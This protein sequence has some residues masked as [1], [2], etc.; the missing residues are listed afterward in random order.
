MAGIVNNQTNIAVAPDDQKLKEYY[1]A[2]GTQKHHQRLIDRLTSY[3][4]NRYYLEQIWLANLL[5]I[6]TDNKYIVKEN[7]AIAKLVYSNEER[8]KN[9]LKINNLFPIY[10]ATFA[11]IW[12]SM[13]LISAKPTDPS[14][15]SNYTAELVETI[16]KKEY[17]TWKN[18]GLH[19]V[20]LLYYICC[21]NSFIKSRYNKD[22]GDTIKL[23]MDNSGKLIKEGRVCAESKTPFQMY[24]DYTKH[25]IEQSPDAYETV[26]VHRDTYRAL[27]GIGKD[28]E[29]KV[30]MNSLKNKILLTGS[31]NNNERNINIA[32]YVELAYYYLPPNAVNT[33][34]E[35]TLF[36]SERILQTKNY[37]LSEEIGLPF[38]QA[39]RVET[40]FGYGDTPITYSV[41]IDRELSLFYGQLFEHA[42]KMASP[43]MALPA[44]SR[45]ESKQLA[46]RNVK[47][48]YFNQKYGKPEYVQS[49]EFPRYFETAIAK[50]EE[51]LADTNTIHN[52]S[53][54][55]H[56]PGTRSGLQQA[57]KIE[58]DDSQFIPDV[59]GLFSMYESV[60]YKQIG[61]MKKYYSEKR[62]VQLFGRNNVRYFSFVGK[63]LDNDLT[64]NIEVVAGLPLNRIQ[65]QSMLMQLLTAGIIQK[66]QVAEYLELGETDP[67]FKR[68][69][70]D[71]LRQ[72]IE[73]SDM[74]DGKFMDFDEANPTK[75][76][77]T[78]ENHLIAICE[79]VEFAKSARY[80]TL[81]NEV[82]ARMWKHAYAHQQKL[83]Q[84][85]KDSPI[86]A[87]YALDLANANESEIQAVMMEVAKLTAK[88]GGM[89]G[90][91]AAG[92]A[93]SAPADPNGMNAMNRARAVGGSVGP[94]NEAVAQP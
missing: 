65:R 48:V 55:K 54:G 76:V 50:L 18:E 89:N 88:E 85:V 80:Q 17:N 62:Y 21:G 43:I 73:I 16:L 14:K 79:I 51:S 68:K 24:F 71:K 64:I 9:Y 22:L 2:D 30:P 77:G 27:F 53:M 8:R 69:L 72:W 20:S 92:P 36:D 25:S 70:E 7:G 60:G 11:K 91:P 1:V 19:G 15:S 56:D 31:Y 33:K 42:E 63:E 28:K 29:A 12:N 37:H 94:Q 84:T 81:D 46:N 87:L 74:I 32:D 86:I 38:S 49:A 67:V 93:S 83:G 78:E 35:F 66:N 75:E 61:L 6:F 26:L 39:K 34:G 47:V 82:K 40:G 59:A 52:P 5:S 45:L 4:Q 10:R 13:P 90:D 23:P 41:A 3:Q 44:G 57:Y 58:A